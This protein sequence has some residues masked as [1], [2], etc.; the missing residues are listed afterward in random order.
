MSRSNKRAST[1]DFLFKRTLVSQGIATTLRQGMFASPFKWAG[2]AL[3]LGS[4]LSLSMPVQAA[5]FTVTNRND[6][7]TGSLRQAVVQA[8]STSGLDD[9]VFSSSV[10]G[11]IKLTSGAINVTD[12]LNI[13]GPGA[14]SLT[15]NAQGAD[16]VFYLH[17][18]AAD[19]GTV[20][21][22]GLTI[23]NASKAGIYLSDYSNSFA[24][25]IIHDSVITGNAGVGV[26]TAV[27][28]LIVRNCNISNNGVGVN[29]YS[30]DAKIINSTISHNAGTGVVATPYG[31]TIEIIDST[32]SGNLKSGID[33]RGVYTA[34]AYVHI[35]GSTI[36]DNQNDSSEPLGYFSYGGGLNLFR[37]S[38]YIENST[39]SNNISSNYGGG[40]GI[41]YN[42]TFDARN[43]T[44]TGNSAG[45]AGGGVYSTTDG[46]YGTYVKLVNSIVADN[47]APANPDM[48][49]PYE[50]IFADYS[51]F[52]KI[53]DQSKYIHESFPGSNLYNVAAK[54]GPLQDNGG[55]TFT[56][57][58]GQASPAIDTIPKGVSGCGSAVTTDQRGELRPQDGNGDG[59][60]ACDMGAYEYS[61]GASGGSGVIGDFIWRD[62]NGNGVQDSGEP[63]VAGVVV[64]LR[65]GCDQHNLLTTKTDSAGSYR[66]K[67]LVSGNYQLEFVK[68]AGYNF[69][70]PIAAG[71][72]TKD[73]NA[74]PSTGL[75]QCRSLGDGQRRL[76]LDAGLIP[77]STKV[78]LSVQDLLVP[79]NVGT[80]NVKVTLNSASTQTV[81]VNYATKPRTALP[82]ED[83]R[84][85]VGTLTFNPGQTSKIVPV[86]IINDN[87]PEPT[88]QFIVK[89]YS[90][91]NAVIADNVGTVTITDGDK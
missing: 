47:V 18:E 39:I 80:A 12:K 35:R 52:S 15:V 14:E 55:P 74:D 65:V 8:N 38:V 78:S 24:K 7:G 79:E 72:Y 91:V 6:S 48:R 19:L 75:D 40:I 43:V 32:I 69:S 36:S 58:L 5:T 41:A 71:D 70:P 53:G 29:V 62:I 50:G 4:A 86:P 77:K 89:I 88:E 68:P 73:S 54:L 16:S 25:A 85:R 42:S 83:Y 61:P 13:H 84:G 27:A 90:P 22:S 63:G 44:I 49:I 56:H 1:R 81:T 26:G 11:S 66:F 76:A 67:G 57:S 87:T 31:R 45:I 21:I 17:R 33:A 30:S 2:S 3:I 28:S 46:L 37:A 51:L 64:N 23:T 20:T 9:I 60:P 82:G 10:S 59:F 34:D